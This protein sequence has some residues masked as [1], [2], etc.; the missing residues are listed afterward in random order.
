MK[1]KFSKYYD[2]DVRLIPDFFG[3]DLFDSEFPNKKAKLITS[4]AMFYDLDEPMNFVKDIKHCLEV[5]GIWH[6]EQS[7]LPMMLRTNSYD[8]ICHEHIE[9][10]SLSVVKDILEKNNLKPF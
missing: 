3:A 4:I 8:T 10:Y 7:Y 1:Y 2:D 5:E 9:F 6:F